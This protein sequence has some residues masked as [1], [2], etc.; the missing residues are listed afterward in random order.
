MVMSKEPDK[1]TTP[2]RWSA[3]AKSEVI[4]RRLRWYRTRSPSL[5]PSSRDPCK[6]LAA[7]S[8]CPQIVGPPRPVD[9]CC[10]TGCC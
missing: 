3:M 1:Q 6:I 10:D 9:S 8:Q 7:T 2:E 5:A 4:L